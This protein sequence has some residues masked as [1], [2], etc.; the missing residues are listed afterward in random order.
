MTDCV[1]LAGGRGTRLKNLTKK[2]PKPLISIKNFIFLDYLL[3]RICKFGLSKVYI[4]ASYKSNQ[5]IK[6]YSKK[7][8]FNTRIEVV[9]E[10]KRKGTGGALYGIKNKIKNDFFLLNGDSFFNIDLN[11]FKKKAKKN[12]YLVNI[13][14]LKN[15]NYKLNNTLA[16]IA[17]RRRKKIIFSNKNLYINGGIYFIKKNFLN[18]IKNKI[19]SLEKD[20]LP[21]LI[22][23][24]KVGG[25]I[26]FKKFFIDIG[27]KKNLFIAKKKLPCLNK[28]K[29]FLLDRDGVINEDR[30]YIYKKKDFKILKGVIEGIKY[31]NTNNYIICV[32]TN[33]SG[34]GR[35]LYDENDLNKLHNY[36]QRRL[37]HAGAYIDKFYFCPFHE[38]DGLGKYKK[39]SFFRKPNPGMLLQAIKDYNI[40]NK[41]S[42]MIGDK[43][44]DEIAAKKAGIKFI[45]KKDINFKKQIKEIINNK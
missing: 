43:P 1:I 24:E 11:D 17:I 26:Y 2:K 39:K 13:A 42:I 22:K 30:G 23:K 33:Q 27:T 20:I 15:I 10:K 28:N 7:K 29:A 14:L 35:G 36:L 41:Q 8:I 32:V 45:Y 16:P 3:W 6:K 38:T 21:E 19:T 37:D 9:V 4:L 18:I 25:E 5:F 12:N 44:T 34:I 31:L 40:C